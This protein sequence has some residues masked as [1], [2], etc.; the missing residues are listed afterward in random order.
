MQGSLMVAKS[1]GIAGGKRERAASG[2]VVIVAECGEGLEERSGWF[3]CVASTVVE[4]E[5]GRVLPWWNCWW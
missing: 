3:I 5:A 4:V 1:I 2:G